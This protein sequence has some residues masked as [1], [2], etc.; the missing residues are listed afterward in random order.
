MTASTI[1]AVKE[2]LLAALQASGDLAGVLVT[3]GV[4]ATEPTS[5]ERVYV[6]DASNIARQ[7]ASLGRLLRSETYQVEVIV[8]HYQGGIDVAAAEDR[9]LA[10]SDAVD[11]RVVADPSL[12]VV[13]PLSNIQ[14]MVAMSS[15]TSQQTGPAANAN[16]VLARV[17][18]TVTVQARI[19]S[20]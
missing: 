12:G 16:G 8:E 5:R 1:P 17:V 20:T 3:R 13:G 9:A 6:G 15:P 14:T 18:M 7:W 19:R 2:A 10:I 4:P 11:A